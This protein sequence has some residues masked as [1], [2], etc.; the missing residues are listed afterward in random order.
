VRRTL[1]TV[2]RS[3]GK[4][5]FVPLWVLAI[6]ALVLLPDLSRPGL[7]E[8]HELQI[9]DAAVARNER[10]DQPPPPAATPPAAKPGTPA[11]TE[12]AR[13][14]ATAPR[15]E[16]GPRTLTERLAA[17]GLR[18]SDSDGGMRLPLALLGLLCVVATAGIA[19]RLGSAR[20]GL[21]AGLACLS[22]PLLVLDARM[23]DGDIGTPTAAA[24]IVYGAVAL[25]T[26]RVRDGVGG[27][28]ALA[29]DSIGALAALAAGVWMG[30]N[31]GGALLGLL[32]PI[33]A[34]AAA[35]GL[36]LGLL[37]AI[38]ARR[39]RAVPDD[40]AAPASAIGR[41]IVAAVAAV[42]AIALVALLADQL[43]AWHPPTPGHRAL[44]GHS[45]FPTDCWSSRLGGMWKDDD[46]ISRGLD[47]VFEQ[48]SFGTFPVGV[49]APIALLALASGAD[50]RRRRA[51]R[52]ALAWAGAS[53]I[54]THM[55]Q[56]KVGFALWPGFPALAVGIGVWLD[57]VLTERA[58]ADRAPTAE[59]GAPPLLA[60]YVVAATATLAV[61]WW[62][63]PD[64]LVSMLIGGDSMKYPTHAHL[65]GV[66]LK[67]WVCL[68]G[69]GFALLFA[70]GVVLWRPASAPDRRARPVRF[71]A[72]RAT[73]ASIASM[74]A[75]AMFWVWGWHDGLSRHLSS[76]HVFSMYRDLRKDDEVLGIK[77][78]MGNAPRY[79][80]GVAWESI[81]TVEKLLDFLAR[82]ARVFALVPSQ[83][84]CAIHRAAAGKPYFVLDDSNPRT[85]LI[86][87]QLGDEE[88]LNPLHST[89][90][91]K[92]PAG[93]A[94]RPPK[95]R[96][97]IYDNK[98]ELIGWT[99]PAEASFGS[100]IQVTL[101][102]KV[103]APV[104][105]SWEIFEH[106]DPPSRTRF[107]GDHFPIH[108]TCA[109]SFW[110]QGDYIVDEADVDTGGVGLSAGPYELWV[111]FF[112]GQNPNWTN[113]KV[114]SAPPGWKDEHDR[115]HL[116]TVD[117]D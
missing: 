32:V 103:L 97:V 102:F 107:V 35:D 41:S 96:H 86:T 67:G 56:R 42:A 54:A 114:T 40:P 62:A 72:R 60:M 78:D 6:A 69:L 75:V 106:F 28:I 105:G 77:G 13:C 91:R 68:V 11:V 90:L 19:I 70:A 5:A 16:D 49:L 24:L 53:W 52:L 88:D 63:F 65:L 74:L 94:M 43:Y 76:K 87:N 22:F 82:P 110:Q 111:G 3:L 66:P 104:G 9:A 21:I 112:T 95:D 59:P 61:D 108:N 4:P 34:V 58:R 47:S 1:R 30:W 37:S 57:G 50:D 33:G 79:Y 31:A 115:V 14:P 81:P 38:G 45:V 85:L 18:V 8:P 25:A 46:D 23:L 89:V 117:L 12:P 39:A 99:I 15:G 109:T 64:R 44:F 83:D 2:F 84:L 113:M 26:P 100:T 73:A 55:W 116:G 29:A 80:A 36:G 98:L 27:M 51:G 48:I 93:I 20:A 17:D 7:W 101:Y 92:E 71:L 10:A